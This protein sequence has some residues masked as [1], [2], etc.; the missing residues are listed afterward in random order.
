MIEFNHIFRLGS[1]IKDMDG[2]IRAEFKAL[3]IKEST[4]TI[5]DQIANIQSKI[6]DKLVELII[7]P[8]RYLTDLEA[9][10][11]VQVR[12]YAHAKKQ[13]IGI[14]LTS[15][16]AQRILDHN[17]LSPALLAKV[18][19]ISTIRHGFAFE[20]EDENSEL[21]L[22]LAKSCLASLNSRLVEI[23]I[24]ACGSAGPILHGLIDPITKEPVFEAER[25][26]CK[27]TERSDQESRAFLYGEIGTIGTEKYDQLKKSSI[28]TQTVSIRYATLFNPS[29]T[30]VLYSMRER[31]N[32]DPVLAHLSVKAYYDM[33]NPVPEIN[34]TR[35]GRWGASKDD[36]SGECRRPATLTFPKA[37]RLISDSITEDQFH[38]EK[39]GHLA[40]PL[41]GLTLMELNL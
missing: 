4:P 2:F 5:S 8:D 40:R 6:A 27:L 16:D 23:V 31:L 13:G 12:E 24:R 19:K 26:K 10:Q 20:A 38:E 30:N 34:P 17:M 32:A 11:T 14:L 7:I 15:S 35:M 25:L 22:K 28:R 3:A 41:L 9:L 29:K 21:I 18:Y 37:I 39:P 1:Y 33:V 36:Q